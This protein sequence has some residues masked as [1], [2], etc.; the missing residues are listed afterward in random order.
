[1]N[2]KK[3]NAEIGRRDHEIEMVIKPPQALKPGPGPEPK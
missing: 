3:K 1:M 2:K